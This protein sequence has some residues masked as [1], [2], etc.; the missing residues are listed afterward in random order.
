VE[1]DV[2]KG[3]IMNCQQAS[4]LLPLWVGHDLPDA[5]ESEGL[6]AHL[7]HCP[8]CSLLARRLQ[9]GL[10]ALQS[11]S[12]AS[13]PMAGERASLWPRLA[14]MLKEV[15]RRRDQFNGWIPAAAMALA[16][17]VMIAVSIVQVRPELGASLQTSWDNERDLFKTDARFAPGSR[18]RELNI[19]GLV[20]GQVIEQPDF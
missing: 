1:F 11:I 13:L 12:S 7:K 17:S 20:A 8:G 16:A 4:R 18:D 3:V 15:P 9:E 5:S 6:R 19:P 14:T 10:E 2:S